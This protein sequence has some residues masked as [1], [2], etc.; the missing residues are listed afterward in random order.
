MVR[1]HPESASSRRRLQRDGNL[2][3][4]NT[5]LTANRSRDYLA[6]VKTE[7]EPMQ[8]PVRKIAG[9]PLTVSQRLAHLED[10]GGFL[11][12]YSHE[13]FTRREGD[14]VPVRKTVGRPRE[15]RN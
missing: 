4:C 14:C 5:P 1:F 12:K 8:Q 3:G 9:R 13:A 7:V 15:Q 10:L 2:C 11:K 6:I